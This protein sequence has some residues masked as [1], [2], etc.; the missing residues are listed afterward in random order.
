MD[1]FKEVIEEAKLKNAFNV[2]DYYKEEK[3][4][5]QDAKLKNAFNIEN[6]YNDLRTII[7]NNLDTLFDKPYIR[8]KRCKYNDNEIFYDDIF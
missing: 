2:E 5:I 6:Y 1:I 8:I 3:K 7:Y 4:V